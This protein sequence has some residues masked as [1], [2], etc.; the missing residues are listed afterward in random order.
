M[1][2]NDMPFISVESQYVILFNLLGEGIKYI[3]KDRMD[4]TIRTALQ[5]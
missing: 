2:S 3:I 5:K 4:Y 1:F